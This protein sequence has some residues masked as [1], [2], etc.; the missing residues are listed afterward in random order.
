M[1]HAA[2]HSLNGRSL[3]AALSL[4]ALA[5]CGQSSA[6]QNAEAPLVRTTVI[7]AGTTA[8]VSYTGVIRARIEADLGF[9]V[10]GKIAERLVDPG[11]AVRAGQ[12][13]MRLDAADLA[14]A[15]RAAD[16]RL[17][18]AEAEARRAK[19]DEERYQSLVGS[20]AIS[21]A[22]YD[23]ALAARRA[24]AA[25]L[26][27]ARADAEQARN[28]KS[29]AVLTADSDGVITDVVA[30]PGQVVAAGT[31][32]VRLA[33][34][35]AREALV[36][37]PENVLSTLP[38]AGSARV[39]GAANSTAAR[40]RE[41]AGTADP[42]TRTYAARY[43]LE[44]DGAASPLGATVT[45]TFEQR[46][47]S[48]AEVP[49]SALHDPGQGPGVWRVGPD[50]KARFLPVR[51]VALGEEQ[52]TV[53]SDALQPGDRIVALGAQL[54]RDGEAVRVAQPGS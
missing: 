18:A 9:R 53:A 37:I 31:I 35:G 16:E 3:G 8:S 21:R 39:Y 5:A 47:H 45:L 22:A 34:A 27:A 23:A 54:L 10:P 13:L 2:R 25:N 52:V 11:Q 12:P 14:L 49:L 15:Q 20:A 1:A 50:D 6:E 26:E 36:S 43:T 46:G 24:T 44:G 38:D 17:R 32:V 42:L 51:I 29:Y 41:V 48:A 19:A 40:L 33:R 30:Q 7:A 28:A 4:L